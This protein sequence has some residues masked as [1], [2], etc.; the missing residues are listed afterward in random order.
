MNSISA[1][2]AMIRSR[3]GLG[4]VGVNVSINVESPFSNG[5]GLAPG[6]SVL[7]GCA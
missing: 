7:V 4:G 2:C 3:L 1:V 5:G 6:F